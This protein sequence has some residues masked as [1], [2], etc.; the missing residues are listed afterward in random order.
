MKKH[1]KLLLS[2]LALAICLFAFAGVESAQAATLTYNPS[3]D[4]IQASAACVGYV[5]KN[6]DAATVKAK[7]TP[8]EIPTAATPLKELGFKDGA[9]IYLY[10][11]D[12]AIEKDVENAKANFILAAPKANKVVGKIDY[13]QADDPTSVNVLS[14]TVTDKDKKEVTD[15]KVIWSPDGT[16]AYEW[17]NDQNDNGAT[18]DD[19]DTKGF[20]GKRLNAALAAGSTVYIKIEGDAGM[21]TSKAYKVK[22][23]KQAKAPAVKLDIKK[24]SLAMKN[25]FD[26][27][28]VTKTGD[29]YGA[30][31]KNDWYTILPYLKTAAIKDLAASIVQ[32]KD[33][34]PLPTK[35]TNAAKAAITVGS[36]TKY[37]YTSY[38]F[39]AVGLDVVAAK[40]ETSL[41][42]GFSFAVRKS[43][44]DKKPA[45]A[46]TYC[47]VAA[48]AKAP[49]IHT[50]ENTEFYTTIGKEDKLTF[51]TPS[52]VNYTSAWTGIGKDVAPSTAADVVTDG[53]TAKY[54]MAVVKAADIAT[55]DWST[56]AWKAIK[57][58]TKI[59]EKTKTKY[60]LTGAKAATTVVLKAG[61]EA[62]AADKPYGNAETVLL[63]RRAGVKGKTVSESVIASDYLTTYIYK[64]ATSKKFY[65]E[66]AKTANDQVLIGEEAWYY[67]LEFKTWQNTAAADADP[68]YGYVLDNELAPI[69]GY[70][71]CDGNDVVIDLPE[72]DKKGYVLSK[73][74]EGESAVYTTVN[75]TPVDGKKQVTIPGKVADANRAN[76]A[77]VSATV[78]VDTEYKITI[79]YSGIKKDDETLETTDAK[80]I[81]WG[82]AYDLSAYVALDSGK[83]YKTVEDKKYTIA[84][85][86]AAED[87]TIAA[88]KLTVNAKNPVVVT[89]KYTEYVEPVAP[90]PEPG[91]ED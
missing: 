38:K 89:V 14:A 78:N 41:S 81:Y 22:I 6:G 19:A 51:K 21:R 76:K 54:E 13:T 88:N 34:L 49:Q 70:A 35:D 7:A 83:D 10:V 74:G 45:S 25:G 52:I 46:I 84:L 69:E 43:A 40:L 16:V 5:M 32:T 33:F 61:T 56:V 53:A 27:A 87:G 11:V 29:T 59:N 28:K 39:K 2:A 66:V 20:S 3:A 71:L 37:A 55:I 50:L 57:A 48:Q 85:E 67:K 31:G 64:D 72:L 60:T 15:A 36:D 90:E 77:E 17:V 9:A 47:D 62:A 12:A 30:I 8:I 18:G 24:N 23:A 68:V 65:W 44:T 4:T 91:G 58:G 42:A 79:K 86:V 26:F 80:P 1:F 75:C 82:Q 63:I 73:V